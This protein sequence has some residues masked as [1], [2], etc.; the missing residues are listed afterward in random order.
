ME[1]LASYAAFA[2][3][4]TYAIAAIWRWRSGTALLAFAIGVAAVALTGFEI[5]DPTL[6]LIQ[7][8]MLML[9]ASIGWVV[10][11][12]SEHY[13]AGESQ[14]PQFYRWLNALLANVAVVVLADNLLLLWAAWVGIS[15]SLHRLLLFFPDRPRAALA[16]HKKFVF[17]RF[18][19]T[20]LLS[21]I[22][23]LYWQY[24]TLSISVLGA[25]WETETTLSLPT[26]L[27]AVLMVS[28][29][30]LKCAQMPFHGWL[31]QV[32]ECPT[33]VSALLHAGVVN[34]GGFLLL[35]LAGLLELASVATA[36]LL[37]VAGGTLVLAALVAATRISVKVGL[38]WST[39][40][41][42]AL[43]L[44][45][46]GLGLYALAVLH[47]VAHSC[48][49]AY[50]FL[51]AGSQ[52]QHTV[53]ARIAPA[54]GATLATALLGTAAA[55]AAYWGLAELYEMRMSVGQWL[56]L[57]LYSVGFSN[58]WR[59]RGWVLSL[60]MVSV[61]VALHLGLKS[62]IDPLLTMPDSTVGNLTLV[63]VAVVV[64]T[65]TAGGWLV[66]FGRHTALHES[67][68]RTLYAGLYLDEWATRL[69]LALWPVHL[70]KP[71]SLARP[72][73]KKEVHS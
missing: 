8:V 26:E 44:L 14:Q 12:F 54:G 60:V 34:L 29:A 69:T 39:V 13:L 49:K 9:V 72:A 73:L 41:Q 48:Y 5:I 3:P 46:I 4:L 7:S 6:T 33:P 71:F 15:L 55:L 22:G 10:S 62:A 21:A 47:L 24:Q 32:V 53:R 27:A 23:L 17:A 20:L 57:G 45:Q 65:L 59:Q 30:M 37:L 16:A 38:A 61:L 50:S 58:L 43:M 42:M 35:R 63:W 11:R 56:L 25:I 19:D 40:A 2:V 1:F 64:L 18:A 70:P 51:N 52:V 67:L 36:V 28:V 68:Y 31:I 66:R